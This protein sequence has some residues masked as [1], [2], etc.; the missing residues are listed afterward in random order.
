MTWEGL[1]GKQQLNGLR[2]TIRVRT[3]VRVKVDTNYRTIGKAIT[4][5]FCIK[6]DE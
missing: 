5:A 6:L 3:S 2:L 1:L 4:L